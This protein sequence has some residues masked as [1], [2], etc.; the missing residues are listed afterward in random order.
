MI[1]IDVKNSGSALTFQ[2]DKDG[3]WD[4]GPEPNQKL[5]F[6][7]SLDPKRAERPTKGE[8][9]SIGTLVDPKSLIKPVISDELL[10]KNIDLLIRML[11]EENSSCQRELVEAMCQEYS[12]TFSQA[13]ELMKAIDK[14]N[15][16]YASTRIF[17]RI[18]NRH[19]RFDI[20]QSLPNADTK[21]IAQKYLGHAYN[22]CYFNPTG[23]YR[24]Q[25]SS[26][27]EREVAL[28]LLMFNR[29][30]KQLVAEGVVTDRSKM[31]N[32]S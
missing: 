7:F 13:K 2:K 19:L 12:F 9:V 18:L 24:L 4:L 5:S 26:Q 21:S 30:Y 8:A 15:K 25:L 27:P 22:F 3:K 23:H 31:G 14:E 20:L 29:K 28:T 1:H 16:I 17:N 6:R 10:E 32:Q 11:I